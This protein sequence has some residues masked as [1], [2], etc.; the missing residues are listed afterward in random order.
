MET[1]RLH[2]FRR[3]SGAGI[4]EAQFAPAGGDTWRITELVMNG[5][6]EVHQ[7]DDLQVHALHVEAL[8]DSLLLRRTDSR[9]IRALHPGAPAGVPAESAP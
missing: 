9:A 2:F 5:D 7:V 6:A 3:G 1:G 8:I 4:Y